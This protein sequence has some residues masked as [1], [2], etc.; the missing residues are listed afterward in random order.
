MVGL[1]CKVEVVC[2]QVAWLVYNAQTVGRGLQPVCMSWNA[3][4]HATLLW[5]KQANLPVIG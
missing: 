3:K 2:S 5:F 1:G 4:F